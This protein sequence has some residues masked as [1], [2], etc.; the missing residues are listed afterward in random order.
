MNAEASTETVL[1]VPRFDHHAHG[2]R[3]PLDDCETQPS[4]ADRA[5][6]AC[7]A[8]EGFEHFL[9]TTGWK[10]NA[11]ICNRQDQFS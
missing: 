5:I 3:E 4:A 2:L 1:A 8:A 6:G 7:K 9:F 11:M 10:A